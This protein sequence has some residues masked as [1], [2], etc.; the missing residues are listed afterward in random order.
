MLFICEEDAEMW[1]QSALDA[2][3]DQN[4]IKKDVYLD[5]S[6]MLSQPVEKFY[7]LSL[8]RVSYGREAA[9]LLD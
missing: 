8:Q 6:L 5:V 4:A 2:N 3:D 9:V 7:F 1:M